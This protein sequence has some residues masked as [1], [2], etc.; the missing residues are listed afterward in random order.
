M[1]GWLYIRPSVIKNQCS[2]VSKHSNFV[3]GVSQEEVG[4][5]NAKCLENRQ[6]FKENGNLYWDAFPCDKKSTIDQLAKDWVEKASKEEY[7]FC[8]HNKGL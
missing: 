3:R 2:W 6:K 8:I 4:R 5:D 1:F 7:D